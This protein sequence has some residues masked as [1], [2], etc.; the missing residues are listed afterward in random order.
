MGMVKFGLHQ[1]WILFNTVLLM[2][3]GAAGLAG[4]IHPGPLL[5]G[6]FLVL[7]VLMAF[8]LGRQSTRYW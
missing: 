4:Y 5:L 3:I 6:V 8:D 2:A 1:L 7:V